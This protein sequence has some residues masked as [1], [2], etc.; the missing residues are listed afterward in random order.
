[1][2]DIVQVV[3][4]NDQSLAQNRLTTLDMLDSGR[5]GGGLAAVQTISNQSPA[6]TIVFLMVS[7]VDD[8]LLKALKTGAR[9]YI[10]YGAEGQE[11]VRSVK[12]IYPGKNYLPY[13]IG[14]KLSTLT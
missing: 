11:L 4:I 13:I 6:S 1:M 2:N 3:A 14:N 10:L 7:E 8:N 9:A 5:G 12:I